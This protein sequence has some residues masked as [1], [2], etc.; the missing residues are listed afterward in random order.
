M[1]TNPLTAAEVLDR[2]FLDVRCR[3]LDVAATLDRLHRSPGAEEIANERRMQQIREAIDI[4]NTPGT[5]RAERLQMLFSDSY[6]PH[7]IQGL[8]TNDPGAQ[9]G[10]KA[11]QESV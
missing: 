4:L 11:F 5:D 8:K 6:I 3:L 1:P 7:W 9:L 2:M 10:G